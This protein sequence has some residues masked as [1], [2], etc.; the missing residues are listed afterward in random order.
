M[1]NKLS[2]SVLI[3]QLIRKFD[4]IGAFFATF[5]ALY[6][7]FFYEGITLERFTLFLVIIELVRLIGWVVGTFLGI[8]LLSKKQ[9]SIHSLVDKQKAH[10]NQILENQKAIADQI[11]TI[12]K[13][14]IKK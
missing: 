10:F 4:G 11:Q 2:K 13:Q 12:S 8:Y 5:L 9:D 3:D 1:N 6:F 7:L 14:I